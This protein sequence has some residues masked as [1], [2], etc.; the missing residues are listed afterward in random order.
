METL[1]P[2]I[3]EIRDQIIEQLNDL[4]LEECSKKLKELFNQETNDFYKLGNL[5]ARVITLKK[6]INLI[7]N[8][9]NED[10]Q[11]VL[12]NGTNKSKNIIENIL[13]GK[14]TDTAIELEW[15]RVQIKETAEVNGVRFPAGIQIDVTNEDSKRMIEGGK[16]ILLDDKEQSG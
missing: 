6:R 1:S 13:D 7:L 10:N 9:S 16:A 11:D 4:T 15:V 5:A 2:Q 8:D 14:P 12:K 3:I